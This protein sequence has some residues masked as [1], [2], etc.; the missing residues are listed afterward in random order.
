M[1]ALK[2]EECKMLTERDIAHE[3]GDFW[4]LRDRAMRRYVVMRS[5]LTHSTFAQTQQQYAALSKRIE[6]ALLH[7]ND[8]TNVKG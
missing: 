5:G 3:A 7:F 8:L 2:E 1:G 4:V 6:E